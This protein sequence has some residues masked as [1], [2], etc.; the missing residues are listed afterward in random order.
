MIVTPLY[1]G[2]L[3]LVFLVVS[4]RVIGHRRATRIDL[5]DGGDRTLL[6][7]Q[8]IHANFAEYVPITLILMTLAELQG[9][10]AWMLHAT[11]LALIIGR[12]THTHAVGREP[13]PAGARVVAMTLTFAALAFAALAVIALSATAMLAALR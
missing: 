13:E 8:R 6:R 1:A 12:L 7:H 10:P 3:A 4:L 9:L 2:L 11:G 5:G